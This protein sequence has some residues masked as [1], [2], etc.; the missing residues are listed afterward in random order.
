[1]TQKTHAKRP[2]SPHLTIYRP[3]ISSVMSI[4]HRATGVALA[5]GSIFFVFWLWS[6]AYSSDCF[7]CMQ[8]IASHILGKIA[9]IAWTFALFYH[10]GNGIRHLFWDMGKGYTIPVMTK[11]GWAVILFAVA[12]TAYVWITIF[13]KLEA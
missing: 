13:G 9:L 6:A 12:S 3:Q 1:M 10:L 11:S 5:L 2:L 7:E 4:C 8:T